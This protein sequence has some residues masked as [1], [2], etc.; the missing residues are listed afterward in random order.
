MPYG[1]ES[2]RNL[3][4]A[5]HVG[6]G[7]TT[8]VE[9]CLATG[10]AIPKPE[11][12]ETGRTASDHTEE[13]IARKISIHTSLT[14]LDWKETR[15][16]FLDTPGSA[17]FVSEVVAAFRASEAV[18]LV[19]GADTGVQIETIKLWRRLNELNRPRIVLIN[20]MEKEHSDFSSALADLKDNFEG[21]FVPVALPI[22]AGAGYRGCISLLSQKAFLDDS[23]GKPSDVPDDMAASV[24][25]HRN[26]VIEA[27]AEGNDT[28]MEKFLEEEELTDAEVLE[29][30][31]DALTENKIVPVLCGAALTGSGIP[32]LLDFLKSV[33]PCPSVHSEIAGDK[34]V[35][36]S[37]EGSFSGYIIKTSIDQFSG[38]ISFIKL[39]TGKM[40]PEMEVIN[41][42]TE[43]KA[44]VSKIYT[45]QGKHLEEAR[46][47]VAGDLGI[48]LKLDG[49]ETGDTL[50]QPDNLVSYDPIRLPTPVHVVAISAA[51]KKDED[52][53]N[54]LLL[55]QSE[56]DPSFKINYN[57]ETKETVISAMGE[58]HL[59]IVLDKIKERQKIEV[60]TRVP[61]VAYRETLTKTSAAEFQ[62]KKQTGGHGQ[63]AKVS[64]EIRPLA[65]GAKFNFTNAIRGGA[66]SKGYIP[67]VEKGILEGME[68][69]YLAGYPIVDLEATV[70]DGKEHPV[71]SSE[72]AF[73]LASKGA[74]REAMTKAG[75][76]LLEPVMNLEVYVDNR[77][78]G[79]VLSDLS[80][81][82]GRVQGQES[83]G[84]GI[85]VI[86]AQV[87][88]AELLRYSI[89]LKSITSGTASFEM[90]FDHYNPISGKIAE[91][92][93]TAS[94]IK[95]D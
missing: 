71:D 1:T 63:Y 68:E 53:L 60:H 21:N 78:L 42:R 67:G 95:E 76:A 30:L 25:E 38:K 14:H 40:T 85:Q 48:L 46:E 89:D 29:G 47:I 49:A 50:C 84:G 44:R 92:V 15:I 90:E 51:S 36:I 70:V 28:L 86:R 69:G 88:Q 77:Y 57:P 18:I 3:A 12:V 81:R 75:A 58:L 8:L 79:D 26:A 32:M 35:P 52:K 17:D 37:S 11:A 22:G 62:H 74:L 5:G 61:R 33:A 73:K 2:I 24:A 91:D 13:E 39:V 55:Q 27:G 72:M 20:K 45:C 80:S 6:T 83:I 59:N 94:K 16:N 65:R 4:V 66:I 31:G 56:E 54:Q 43:Q 41:P 10:G 23:R 34:V 64:I 93:I 82:R 87:P 7:K 9:N 19:V